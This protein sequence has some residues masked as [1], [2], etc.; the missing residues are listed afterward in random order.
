MGFFRGGVPVLGKN[1]CFWAGSGVLGPQNKGPKGPYLKGPPHPHQNVSFT[2][3]PSGVAWVIWGLAG[4]VQKFRFVSLI[5]N[6]PMGGT[7]PFWGGAKTVTRAQR[8]AT[9]VAT[10]P[11]RKRSFLAG[12]PYPPQQLMMFKTIPSLLLVS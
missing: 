1:S 7:P 3:R 12:Y 11:A 2:G 10:G 4:G 6:P 8:K 5:L 9:V